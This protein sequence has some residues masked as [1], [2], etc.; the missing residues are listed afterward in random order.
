MYMSP[1]YLQAWCWLHFL[2]KNLR[3]WAFK[4][5][6]LLQADFGPVS[7]ACNLARTYRD[8]EDNWAIVAEILK[9][10]GDD[11]GNFSSV[12]G[13]GFWNDPDQVTGNAL[14]SYCIG[15]ALLFSP[16]PGLFIGRTASGNLQTNRWSDWAEIR[17]SLTMA[18]L[19]WMQFPFICILIRLKSNFGGPAH[20][21]PPQT[22]LT[23]AHD[24]PNPNS[25]SY[26][27]L[28]NLHWGTCLHCLVTE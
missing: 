4:Y 6:D 5:T 27:L 2:C 7:K 17:A 11:A 8:N 18:T 23:F 26:P 13:P 19:P 10:F 15:H 22:W 9:Y 28:F 20:C 12:A 25:D 3:K 14:L 16:F 1:N 21:G 24:P